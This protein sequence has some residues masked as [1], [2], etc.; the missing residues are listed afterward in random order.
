MLAWH[1]LN[2]ELIFPQGT[3]NYYNTVVNKMGGLSNVQ[4]FYKLYLVPGMGHGTPNGTSNPDAVVPVVGPTQFYD[5]LT[6]W[7]EKGTAPDA[8]T[9]A[10]SSGTTRPICVYPKK[11]TYMNGD[12]K[13]AASYTCS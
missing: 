8:I 10:H 5:L 2:D 6:A 12:L 3:I 4:D 13:V 7:V 11:V 1:G 9:L